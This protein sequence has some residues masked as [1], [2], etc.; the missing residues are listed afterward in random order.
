MHLD[1]IIRIVLNGLRRQIL[2]GEKAQKNGGI[3]DLH[4]C[5]SQRLALLLHQDAGDLRHIGL[6]MARQLKKSG[7]TRFERG[8][9][10][11][12]LRRLGRGDGGFELVRG[13]AGHLRQNLARGR[14]DDVEPM[15]AR[16]ELTVDQQIVL[17]HVKSSGRSK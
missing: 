3:A 16:N 11:A 8:R 10:P 5:L 12:G 2:P 1:K 17:S 14:V 6:D 13:S 15:V 9:G 4:L 7:A